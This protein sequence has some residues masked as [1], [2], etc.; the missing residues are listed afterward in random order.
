MLFSKFFLFCLFVCFCFCFVLFL[1]A[2]VAFHILLV[3]SSF[4]DRVDPK[5]TNLSTVFKDSHQAFSLVAS[6]CLVLLPN[7]S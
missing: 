7:F 2:A 1:N 4:K 3:N 5:Q 6:L